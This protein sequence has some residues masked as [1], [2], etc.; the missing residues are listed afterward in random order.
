MIENSRE[1]QGIPVTIYP[2]SFAL[3]FTTYKYSDQN[4]CL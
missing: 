1:I 3:P 4:I 2:E